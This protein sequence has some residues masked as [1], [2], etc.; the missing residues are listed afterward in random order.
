MSLLLSASQDIYGPMAAPAVREVRALAIPF[1]ARPPLATICLPGNAFRLRSP[2]CALALAHG[3]CL[4]ETAL[5]HPR[6]QA[7]RI[8]MR[9]DTN[10]R[11]DPACRA[12]RYINKVATE[13]IDVFLILQEEEPEM[14]ERQPPPGGASS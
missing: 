9:M 2:G 5:L 3:A 10:R 6:T 8:F 7:I 11:K 12:L 1:V 4:A 13:G 14:F